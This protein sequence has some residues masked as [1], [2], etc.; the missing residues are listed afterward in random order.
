MTIEVQHFKEIYKGVVIEVSRR[1]S[2]NYVLRAGN[3]MVVSDNYNDATL[4]KV[5]LLSNSL[6]SSLS[7]SSTPPADAGT[8]QAER[9]GQC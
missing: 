5:V 7:P 1:P 9:S 4:D 3:T 2:G 8:T 6:S